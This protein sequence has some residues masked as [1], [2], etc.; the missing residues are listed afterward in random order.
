MKVA[1]LFSGGKDSVFSVFVAQ[2]YGWDVA[3]LVTVVPENKES[4]M[5][6]S[7]NLSLVDLQS[8]AIGIP[9]IKQETKGEKEEELQELY[10]VLKKLDIAGVISG[11]IA[12]EYQRTRI[13]QVC[14]QLNIKSFTPLWHKDPALLLH[15]YV[16]AGF[17]NMI[18]GV[19]AH[20]FTEAWL[21]RPID[22]ACIDD[23][24]KLQKKYRINVGGEGGE[25][26]TLALD[27]PLFS[28][29]LVL[30][31]VEKKWR[32]DYGTAIVIKSHLEEK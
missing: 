10:N 8:Q 13:E 32:R 3:Y 15:Q 19:F 2:Q 31:K 11:A 18:V 28:K 26:E 16:S 21:G 20:G 1:A 30:D 4:W 6:H 14:H 27:G 22:E 7:L 9:L 5:Y 24:L 12:S 25:Y 29:K 17:H 23:L